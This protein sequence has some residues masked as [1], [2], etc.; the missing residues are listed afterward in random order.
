MPG[1][2][3]VALAFAYT[4]LGLELICL[5]C[6][7]WISYREDQSEYFTC[8]RGIV[9]CW[10]CVFILNVVWMLATSVTLQNANVQTLENYS[11]INDCADQH[12]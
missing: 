7:G 5:G 12:T 10:G 9:T 11:I 4:V 6:A 8:G 2:V 1:R 3:T